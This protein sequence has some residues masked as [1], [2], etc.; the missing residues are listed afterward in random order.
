MSSWILK[1]SKK[2]DSTISFSN[3]N[4]DSVILMGKR[5][6]TWNVPSFR[7]GPLPLVLSL[8]TTEK[9]LALSFLFFC[10]FRYLYKLIRSPPSLPFSRLNSPSCLS[11]S[12][13]GRCSGP[14]ITLVTFGWSLCSISM[15]LLYWEAQTENLEMSHQHQAEGKD[16]LLQP[17]GNTL[18]ST[19]WHNIWLFFATRAYCWLMFNFV[20]VIVS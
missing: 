3:L 1:A 5:C 12:P 18:P 8:R 10:P 11:L 19:P 17:A 4:R 13:L 20:E 2:A 14:F 15:S 16:Q 9:N 7:A 6:F